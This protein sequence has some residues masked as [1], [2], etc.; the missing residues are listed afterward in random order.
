MLRIEL[1][2]DQRD[3]LGEGPLWDV[4]EQRLYW[5]DSYGPAVHS[6]DARGGERKSWPVPEP[7][8][9]LALRE[10]GGA[11]VALR[12]GF[13]TL[14]FATGAVERICETQPG[15]LRP[16]LNDG[17]VDRQGRFLAG[18][19]DFEESDPVGALFRLDPDLS[20]HE[21]D[22]GIVCSNGPCFSPD[23]KTLY[24]ADT[25][26]RV[27]YAYDY[28]TATGA[29]RSRRVFASFEGMRGLPDGATV[30]AEGFVWSVEVYS[31]RLV[32]FDP[33]GVIDRIVNLPVE[34]TTSLT[35]GGPDLDVVFVTSMARPYQGSYHR[36]REAGGLFAVIGLGVRGL[37]EPRFLG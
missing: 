3:S 1:L 4:D 17:K 37:P 15:E 18:S 2:T 20:V 7:I 5:I 8:G 29:V 32:R 31:G 14:D 13:F 34:S 27:I 19:M 26:R 28:D 6:C 36:H 11:I 12:S 35:F 22:R 9:S 24:F 33:N 10:K 21:L 16:R 23:G 30:D 25:G